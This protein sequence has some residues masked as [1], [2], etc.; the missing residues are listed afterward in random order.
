[1]TEEER[2]TPQ[3]R[4]VV[5]LLVCSRP[6]YRSEGH[7]MPFRARAFAD[8]LLIGCGAP[9]TSWTDVRAVA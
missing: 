7:E 6:D 2:T 8:A 9:N 1:M 3:V 5:E 4:N